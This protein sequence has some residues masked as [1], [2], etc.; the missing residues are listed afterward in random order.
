M[1]HK[2]ILGVPVPTTTPTQCAVWLSQHVSADI[3][4]SVG[5][6]CCA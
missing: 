1:L 2:I 5:C 4:F 3:V 6:S